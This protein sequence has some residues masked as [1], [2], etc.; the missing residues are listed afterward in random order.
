MWEINLNP[1]VI[2]GAGKVEETGKF[3]QQMG[4]KALIVTYKTGIRRTG[5][6]DRVENVLEREGVLFS[7]YEG[8]D[9]DPDIASIDE[10][11]RL[12]KEGGFDVVIGVGGGSALDA[13]K[14]IAML[15]TNG[16]SIRDYQMGERTFASPIIPLIAI[17]TTAG[18]G[19]EATRVCVVSNIEAGIK[20]SVAHPYMVP[21]LALIDPELMAS[22][23][24][25]LT[26]S[27]GMDALGHAIES[28][29]SLNANPVT[30][31][32]GIKS[33][34][35]ISQS[36]EEAVRNGRNIDARMNMAVASFMAGTALNAGV[37][38]A[39]LIGQPLGAV[40][41]IAHGDAISVL[42]PSAMI[43]NLEYSPKKYA[44]I[45]RAMGIDCHGL[46]DIEAGKRA[47]AAVEELRASVG[48]PSSL[49]DIC[50][51]DSASFPDV[52]DSINRSTAHIKCNPRPVDEGLII[53][54]LNMVL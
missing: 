48:A 54:A 13:S 27:T 36:L 4:S 28:Y 26:A 34:E 43:L 40:Y 11:A 47:I 37:G 50:N 16:G 7:T 9:P 42:L 49:R 20:K 53:E 41:H 31:A 3:V 1:R 2:C 38:I 17:P 19:S 32:Y 12:C 15:V 5:I 52:L 35:L 45:A 14:A 51:A 29:V 24:E 23:P 8:V 46:S 44:D 30:E 25:K 33:V 39:H 21:T 6:L 22:L 18:T 10:G